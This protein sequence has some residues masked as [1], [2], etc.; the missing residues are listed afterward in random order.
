[1]GGMRE[2]CGASGAVIIGGCCHPFPSAACGERQ[3]RKRGG[4]NG[5]DGLFGAENQ[6]E[7]E[8]VFKD[9]GASALVCIGC[10]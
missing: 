6:G 5:L 8:R 3:R 2:E 10:T 9:L 1:M 7:R 4:G